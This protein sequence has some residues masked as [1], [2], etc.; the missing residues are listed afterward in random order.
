MGGVTEAV[1][2]DEVLRQYRI[3]LLAE[4]EAMHGLVAAAHWSGSR[5]TPYARAIAPTDRPTWFVVRTLGR[6]E[7]RVAERLQAFGCQ[8][9]LPTMA[10]WIR[11]RRRSPSGMAKRERV[12]F[13][14]FPG[15]LFVGFE[16]DA[17]PV[18]FAPITETNGVLGILTVDGEP[19]AVPA[20]MIDR[21]RDA[22]ARGDHDATLEEAKRLANL[23]GSEF[24]I[25]NGPFE[26]HGGIVTGTRGKM[27]EIKLDAFPQAR[28]VLIRSAT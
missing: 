15:Y 13:P 2:H 10:K 16:P 9:L 8:T 26:G 11:P 21:F 5:R 14:L 6:H 25:P 17:Q 12:E 1:M 20:E 28:P 19:G 24:T 7:E 3:Q 4:S 22:Q 18:S 23:I 27:A